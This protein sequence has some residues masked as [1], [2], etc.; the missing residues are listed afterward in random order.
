MT[1]SHQPS[2]SSPWAAALLPAA[3]LI[4]AIGQGCTR[5]D[6]AFGRS[7]CP[8]DGCRDW[9]RQEFDAGG[10]TIVGFTP[11]GPAE[12]DHLVVYIEGDGPTWRRRLQPRDP[13]PRR[14][15]AL[16]LAIHD[17]WPDVVYLAR[18]CQYLDRR[19][20]AACPPA[21]WGEARFSEAVVAA[22]DIAVS[23]AKSALG[24]SRLT[25]IG[26]SGGGAI[27]T[28]LA[29]RRD[30]VDNL[31]TVAGTLDHA[32][33]TRLHDVPPLAASLNP[34]D[35]APATAAV[36][37]VHLVGGADRV[38]PPEIGR[39]FVERLGSKLARLDVIA[40]N[41]HGCCWALQWADILRRYRNAANASL[42]PQSRSS[43][44]CR[45]SAHDCSN[46]PDLL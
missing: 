45:G 14:P 33:F 26:F 2:R 44:R 39:N 40:V 12:T 11:P 10:F 25:L 27:A 19:R 20:L 22:M 17:P 43:D 6:D 13:T 35:A 34:I 7:A 18:P 42:C 32:A 16:S 9:L 23:K 24:A 30:D 8:V 1:R 29:A 38:V 3:C 37:Q 15:T 31:M 46:A 5:T 36:C 21:Y 4:L 41:D 28:L